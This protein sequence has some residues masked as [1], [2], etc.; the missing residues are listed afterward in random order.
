MWLPFPRLGIN[1]YR[2]L[3]PRCGASLA[4]PGIVR[5]F[6]GWGIRITP[7]GMLYNVSGSEAVEIRMKNVRRFRL[8]TD[9]PEVLRGA[10]L[11][12]MTG[13]PS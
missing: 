10:I 5:L 12:A 13:G 6:A 11:K 4:E 1:G 3:P 9:E 7:H 8:G 2:G